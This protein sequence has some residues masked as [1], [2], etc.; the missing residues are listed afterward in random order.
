M[1]CVVGLLGV[2]SQGSESEGK[3]E[4]GRQGRRG[5]TREGVLLSWPIPGSGG[6]DCATKPREPRAQ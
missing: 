1:V 5:H 3:A 2:Q 4:G 6:W